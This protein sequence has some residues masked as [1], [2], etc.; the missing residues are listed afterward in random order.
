MAFKHQQM[1]EMVP[2]YVHPD[3]QSEKGLMLLCRAPHYLRASPGW[4]MGNTVLPYPMHLGDQLISD[5]LCI[6]S[7]G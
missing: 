7:D 3:L 2:F 5:Q 6:L 4:S 1:V